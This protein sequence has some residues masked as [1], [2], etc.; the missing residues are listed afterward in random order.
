MSIRSIHGVYIIIVI[1]LPLIV[2]Q[3]DVYVNTAH[4]QLDLKHGAVSHSLLK[5]G[6][7]VL[8]DECD[9]V[10]AS[11]GTGTIVYWDIATTTRGRLQCKHIIIIHTVGEQYK[12]G[13]SEKVNTGWYVYVSA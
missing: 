8:Q 11:L 1:I 7:S 4:N 10:V 13:S 6:G 9:R 2:S 3:A 5:D 12:F